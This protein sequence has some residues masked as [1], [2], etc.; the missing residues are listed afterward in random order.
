MSACVCVCTY[1]HTYMHTNITQRETGPRERV[2]RRER[3]TARRGAG[4]VTCVGSEKKFFARRS[5]RRCERRLV[6]KENVCAGVRTRV[7]V[8]I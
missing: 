8:S 5:A 4:E 6:S 1:T 2:K 3:E 7:C